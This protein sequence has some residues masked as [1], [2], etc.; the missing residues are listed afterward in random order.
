MVQIDVPVAFAIGSI[1]ADAAHKQL[2]TG[3]LEYYYH[4]FTHNNIYQ[5]LFFIWIPVYFLLNYFRW[6]TTHV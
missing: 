2:Q 5:I 4:A 6:E 3:R 1:F